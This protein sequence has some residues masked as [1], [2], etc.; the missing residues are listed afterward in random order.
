[1]ANTE[2]ENPF[3]IW[4]Y[5]TSVIKCNICDSIY[6]SNNVQ[7]DTNLLKLHLERDHSHIIEE[8]K[9]EI[10]STWMSRYFAFDLKCESITCIFC[11]QN[12]RI[13]D[14]INLQYHM[15]L[16]NIHEHTI[17]YLKD[18]ETMKQNLPPEIY[19]KIIGKLRDEITLSGLSS[20][21]IFDT[22]RY[23]EMKCVIC[24]W[25]FNILVDEQILRYHL[26]RHPNGK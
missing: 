26:S 20:Y 22:Q 11:G 9:N 16:H 17:N 10:K 18:D 21:F 23:T 7:V 24:H 14:G 12:I 13:L 2:Q 19:V 4:R 25:P 5:F 1:M 6:N 15:L 8:I 3:F